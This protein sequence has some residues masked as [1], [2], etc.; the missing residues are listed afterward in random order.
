[1]LPERS[2]SL[3]MFIAIAHQALPLP[4][5]IEHARALLWSYGGLLVFLLAI[6]QAGLCLALLFAGAGLYALGHFLFWRTVARERRLSTQAARNRVRVIQLLERDRVRIGLDLALEPVA[7]ARME[8]GA[9]LWERIENT[10]ES[11]V[12]QSQDVLR[13]RIR[14]AARAAM[15]EIVALECGS[16]NAEGV[17]YSAA[18]IRIGKLTNDLKNL[19]L[20]TEAVTIVMDSYHRS[21]AE[22]NGAPL[23]PVFREVVDLEDLLEESE[24]LSSR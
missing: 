19:S 10:L 20:R 23:P 6:G 7:V 13:H 4:F 15:E 8:E 1:M 14:I 24:G 16:L 12:W 9:N 18:D 17:V 22:G 2:R 11:H 21:D 3:S 5:R